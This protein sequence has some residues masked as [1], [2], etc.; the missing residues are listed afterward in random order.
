MRVARCFLVLLTSAVILTGLVFAAGDGPDETKAPADLLRDGF[1]TP[2]PSWQ[3][4]HTDTVVKLFEHDRSQRAA[5]EGRLSEHFHFEAGP[6]SQ[7]FVSYPTPQV[8]VSGDLKV[9]LFVRSDRAGVRIYARVVL[10]ADVDP[11]TKE[12]S[13]VLVPGT[14][15]DQV[16]RW[17]KL[18]LVEMMPAI[19]R[20][21]RVLRVSTR[22]P[23]KLE[24]AY[25]ER[26]VV[27][28]LGGPGESQ[29]FLDDLT[30]QPVPQNVLAE[31]TK[32]PQS[33]TDGDPRPH[34]GTAG[35]NR[36]AT[37]QGPIR[38][39]R[40]LLEKRGSDGIFRPWFP[41]AIEAPG[42]NPARLRDA[43]FGILIDSM[44]TD[45]EKLQPAIA[46]GALIMARMS[47]A[48]AGD[49][50]DQVR[51]QINAYPLRGSVAFWQM[52]NHLGKQRPI[53]AR[54]E[55]LANF[56]EAIAAV[57][58][59]DDDVS[60]LTLATVE[61][62][63]GLFARAPTGLD[64]VA[65]EPRFWG[66]VQ[67]LLECYRY[68]IQRRSLTVRSNLGLLF[69]GSIPASTPPEVTRNIWGDDTP[70]SWG[71]P[72]VQ[73]A[74]LRQMTYLTLAAGYRGLAYHGDADL[75]RRGGAGRALCIEMGFLNAEIGLC[76]S[77][78]AQNEQNFHEYGVFDP[79]P[80]PVPSNATQLS[81]RR[82]PQIKELSPR[83]GM[84]AA[85]IPLKENK[86]ALVIVGDFASG[87]QFQPGQLAADEVTITVA[88]PEGAQAFEI[89]PGEVKVLPRERAQ[90]GTRITLKEF[91]TTSLILCTGD[92]AMYE[93][94]RLAV[95]GLRPVAVS[96]AIEQSQILLQAVTEANGRLAADGHQFRSKV[97]L[98]R[99]RQAGIVGAPPDVPDLL[100]ES[101]A[102]INSAREAM[103]RQDYGAAWAE[104]RRAQRPLRLVMNGHWGQAQE[105]LVKAAK[106][107]YP[108]REGEED[109]SDN[110]ETTSKKEQNIDR[111]KL[112]R[113]PTLLI[114]AVSCPPSISFFTLPEA[115]IWTDWIKGQPGYRFGRN[116]IP[117]G[118]FE[119]RQEIGEA[120]WVDMS[121]Q[122]DGLISKVAVVPRVDAALKK[123]KDENKKKPTRQIAGAN[124]GN[125]IKLEVKAAKPGQLDTSQPF[126]DFPV[127]AIRTP[128]IPVE[129]NNLIRISVLVKRAFP[130]S[131]GMGGVIIRDSIGGEQFQF[132]TS[133]PIAEYSRVLLFRKAPADG[134]F[135]VT[136]GLAGYGEAL[137]DDLRVEVIEQD[138]DVA[139][140]DIVQR[141]GPSRAA[142]SPRPPE[143]SPPES[144]SR[145]TDRGRQPR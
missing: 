83:P 59:L 39:E 49:A 140:P 119:D 96:L 51:A 47:G 95:E 125:V 137:F 23:V 12:P 29:V 68:M 111:P 121:Y 114:S 15:F 139:A 116:R 129:R 27:N 144:A 65:I 1:E 35:P 24:G 143:P 53:A 3:R 87:S 48:T 33:P 52:G 74:Q 58:S 118:D 42:A 34:A 20:Q 70:P 18:E 90:V 106:K 98:K 28:L 138:Y 37:V 108:L 67:D 107:F 55:E 16:D 36:G 21:A 141:R 110:D 30:I 31:W 134:T 113:N 38:L 128:P 79:D 66:G 64:M 117:S 115:Y 80:L 2:Q 94:L 126:L 120:G 22:R 5:H 76:E 89:T 56:R 122:V 112:P 26:V 92:L 109:T 9:G 45:P 127:A 93:Q 40:N 10:P 17:Q 85:A 78:L 25:L 19:E 81:S 57:R 61:G 13:Y 104:A 142:T 44:K 14:I 99:R 86:G 71:T 136:L 73:P 72:P 100:K 102:L 101:Q 75:T 41:T 11:D 32:A 60:H 63:L 54:E 50:P 97:D 91:D 46:R 84:L 133:G 62:E 123:Q 145:P 7:F 82:P 105:A 132:R 103:E 8:P 130:S 124:T 131:Q 135:T 4:E 69:W 77:I 6:G 88:L 43:G